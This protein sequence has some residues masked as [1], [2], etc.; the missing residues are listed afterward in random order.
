MRILRWMCGVTG[1]N[2]IKN[3]YARECLRVTNK[4]RKKKRE[5]I[6]H[7]GHVV[8]T[9]II[10]RSSLEDKW[11]KSKVGEEVGQKR[12]GWRLLGKIWVA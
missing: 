8:R 1:L 2:R 11:N 9:R 4:S 10:T 7:F 3:E 5:F 12:N 6:G